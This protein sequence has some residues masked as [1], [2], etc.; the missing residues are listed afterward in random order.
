MNIAVVYWEDCDSRLGHRYRVD[1][2][3]RSSELIGFQMRF[4]S[5]LREKNQQQIPIYHIN[6]LTFDNL[7]NF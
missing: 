2:Q 5:M 7:T 4:Y 6:I 1:S 3:V